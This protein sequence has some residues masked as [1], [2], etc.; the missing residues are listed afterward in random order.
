MAIFNFQCRT[1]IASKLKKQTEE[2]QMRKISE[3]PPNC[4]QF[5]WHEQYEAGAERPATGISIIFTLDRETAFIEL[6]CFPQN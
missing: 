4:T 5:A 6:L 1:C 3:A 2:R